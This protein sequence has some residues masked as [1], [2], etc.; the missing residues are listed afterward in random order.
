MGSEGVILGHAAPVG[1]DDGFA[2][3]F[4]ANAV[5]PVVG[6]G[7]AA[8]R[9]A[10]HRHAERLERGHD[11]GPQ[12]AVPVGDAAIDAAAQM[13][14]KLAVDVFVDGADTLVGVDEQKRHTNLRDDVQTSR[15]LVSNAPSAALSAPAG[16]GT[17]AVRGASALLMSTSLPAAGKKAASTSGS[18]G[19]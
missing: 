8:A 3:F 9:P 7:K 17:V 12:A 5:T 16:V 1:V 11:I 14:R 4:G 2:V 19:R 18:L 13:L 10:Q 15:I 6:I